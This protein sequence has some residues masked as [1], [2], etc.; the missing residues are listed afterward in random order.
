MSLFPFTHTKPTHFF[1]TSLSFGENNSD[2]H[3]SS[4]FTQH[5]PSPF[6]QLH[7]SLRGILYYLRSLCSNNFLPSYIHPP[8][9]PLIHN[10]LPQ[11]KHPSTSSNIIIHSASQQNQSKHLLLQPAQSRYFGIKSASIS[12]L[13]SII[14]SLFETFTLNHQSCLL[15]LEKLT[16]LRTRLTL[17]LACLPSQQTLRSLIRC[18]IRFVIRCLRV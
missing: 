4:P 1:L 8:I 17:A 13:S 3:C 10:I 16:S 6:T 9:H 11:L 15:H 14:S 18:L 7:A 12:N 2:I 5:S